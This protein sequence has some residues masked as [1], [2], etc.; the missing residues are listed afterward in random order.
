V[1]GPLAIRLEVCGSVVSS[2]S[3]PRCGQK[4]ILCILEVTKKR[5][6]TPFSVFLGDDGASK[7]SRGPGKL[8]PL[9]PLSTGLL[10]PA[11]VKRFIFVVV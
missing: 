4:W 3:G 11:L 10:R 6:G 5:F 7:T 2:S 9:P 1:G 8:F